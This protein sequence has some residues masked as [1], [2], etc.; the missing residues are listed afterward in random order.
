MAKPDCSANRPSLRETL[1]LALPRVLHDRCPQCGRG[2]LFRRYARLLERCDV[3]GLVYRRE[4]GAEL[5]AMYLSATVNQFF[6]A[7]VVL[8]VWLATDW[9]PAASLLVSTPIVLAFCTFFLPWSMRLW[10][11]L[12]YAHD[13]ANREWWARPRRYEIRRVSSPFVGRNHSGLGSGL[14]GRAKSDS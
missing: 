1:A 5:G 10:T 3:C 11:A 9:G 13:V 4:H 2:P 6:T 14:G 12:D 7:A 8:A